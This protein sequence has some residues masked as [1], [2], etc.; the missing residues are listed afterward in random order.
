MNDEIKEM[1]DEN[2]K[3]NL[4]TLSN[5]DVESEE[6]KKVA[7]SLTVLYKLKLEDDK[8]KNELID[9]TLNREREEKYKKKQL[10]FNCVEQ[11]VKVGIVVIEVAVP[12]AFYTVWMRAGF[13][14]E[15]ENTFTSQTFRNLFARFKPAK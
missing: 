15:K 14:F 4:E 12:I 6:Y 9:K 1:L 2:L 8:V 7:E 13:E 11:G 5:L 3:A 10:I